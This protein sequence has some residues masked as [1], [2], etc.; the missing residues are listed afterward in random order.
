MMV[1]GK[2]LLGLIAAYSLHSSTI[3][4]T[5]ILGQDISRRVLTTAVPF[6]TITPDARSGGLGETGSP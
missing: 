6:L 2:V 4:Q 1:S 3:G 5:I